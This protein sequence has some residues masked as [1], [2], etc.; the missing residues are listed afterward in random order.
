MEVCRYSRNTCP[1]S[2]LCFEH[3]CEVHRFLEECSEARCCTICFW[4]Q[5]VQ[6]WVWALGLKWDKRVTTTMS[7]CNRLKLLSI[8]EGSTC[9]LTDY[10][11]TLLHESPTK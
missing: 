3:I 5:S 2:T 11:P 4:S 6:I 8:T 9:S 7:W 10:T 1:C